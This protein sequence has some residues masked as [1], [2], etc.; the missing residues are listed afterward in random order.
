MLRWDPTISAGNLIAATAIVGA[1][2]AAWVAIRER[3]TRIETQ[4]EPM[5]KEFAE[6]RHTRRRAEDQRE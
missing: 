1:I 5:W 2:V 4:L 6:R 3:L